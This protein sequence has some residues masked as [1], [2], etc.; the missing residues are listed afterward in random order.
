MLHG[1]IFYTIANVQNKSVIVKQ[2]NVFPEASCGGFLC[3]CYYFLKEIVI[4]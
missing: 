1:Q 3:Y 2:K 4:M